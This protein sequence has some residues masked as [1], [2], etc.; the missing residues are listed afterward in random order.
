MLCYVILKL[1]FHSSF[2]RA[3]LAYIMLAEESVGSLTKIPSTLSPFF[4]SSS[5]DLISDGI[6]S[7]VR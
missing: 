7:L 3:N 2:K 4:H 6:R 1:F 5:G